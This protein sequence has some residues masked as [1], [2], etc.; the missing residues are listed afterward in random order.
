MR[1]VLFLVFAAIMCLTGYGSPL[2]MRKAP[3]SIKPPSSTSKDLFLGIKTQYGSQ[4]MRYRQ[5]KPK[6]GGKEKVAIVCVHGFGGNADQFRYQMPAFAEAGHNTYSIDL[7]GYGYSDK[8]DP[9]VYDV[10][11]VYNFENWADQLQQFIEEVVK[12][13]CVI[14]TNSV[15]GLVGLQAAVNQETEKAKSQESQKQKQRDM[16]KGVVRDED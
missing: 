16:I 4:N 9:S 5:E 8:I 10:N 11:S 14:M 7:L 2:T 1:G 12:Q 13:P 15:G 6:K 3:S